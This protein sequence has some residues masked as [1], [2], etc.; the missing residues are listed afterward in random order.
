MISSTARAAPMLKE[1]RLHEPDPTKQVEVE[2]TL[3]RAIIYKAFARTVSS[4]IDPFAEALAHAFLYG[5]PG[6]CARVVNFTAFR[7]QMPG[8]EPAIFDTHDLPPIAD[9]MAQ[10][11]AAAFPITAE[12]QNGKLIIMAPPHIHAFIAR[13]LSSMREEH[14]VL[15]DLEIL[16]PAE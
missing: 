10:F 15:S 11:L 4:S 2:Q 5:Q 13:V 1:E 9:S 7:W 14:S 6:A 3:C 12:E 16:F 8:H